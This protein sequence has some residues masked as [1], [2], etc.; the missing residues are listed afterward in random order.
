MDAVHPWN[1]ID[2]NAA[3]LPFSE[4]GVGGII[5][6]GVHISGDVLIG[7]GSRIRSGTYIMGPVVIGEGSD[8]GPNAAIYPSTSIGNNV[9]IAPF[10]F[11]DRSVIGDDI[12]IMAGAY[13]SNSVLDDGCILGPHF[14]AD[15]G[16]V[17]LPD[18]DGILHA[19]GRIGVM[20]GEDVKIEGNVVTAPGTIIGSECSVGPA[21]KLSGAIP[22]RTNVL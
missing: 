5:E 20:I 3:S 8:I 6:E 7:K 15:T 14:S 16:S 11:I 22:N 9:Q 2:V 1:I 18:R 10:S 21:V 19:V 12:V 4:Q 17:K 13:I